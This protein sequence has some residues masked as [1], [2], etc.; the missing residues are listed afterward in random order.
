MFFPRFFD[1][2]ESFFECYNQRK[3]VLGDTYKQTKAKN[4]HPTE[5]KSTIKQK[6]DVGF[7]NL[8]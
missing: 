3:H 1:D 8:L 4:F 6:L 7:Q 2:Q 5:V